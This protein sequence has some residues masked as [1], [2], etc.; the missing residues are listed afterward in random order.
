MNYYYYGT[1]STT[2]FVCSLKYSNQKIFHRIPFDTNKESL[3]PTPSSSQH[4]RRHRQQLQFNNC[5]K[6]KYKKKLTGATNPSNH[7]QQLNCI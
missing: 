5:N 7:P 6:Q 3:K 1:H 2:M 4:V